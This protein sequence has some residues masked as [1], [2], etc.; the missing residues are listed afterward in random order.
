MPSGEVAVQG[1]VVATSASGGLS[2]LKRRV[3]RRLFLISGGV[4]VCIP[5]CSMGLAYLPG[6]FTYIWVVLGVNVG[7]YTI[8]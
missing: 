7:K 8:H 6:L 3:F 5:R 4:A 2:G 1:E